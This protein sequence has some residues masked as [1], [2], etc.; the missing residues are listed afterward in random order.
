MIRGLIFDFDGLIIDSETTDFQSWQEIFEA[1]GCSLPLDGWM[2]NVGRASNTFDVYGA[3]EAQAGRNLDRA[4]IRAQHR[5]RN[6]NMLA[7]M[8]T[9]PGVEATIADARRAG[10][11]L[12]VASSSSREWV[13]GHLARLGY[14]ELFDVVKC[15]EDVANAKPAPD[16]F[17]AALAAL[18]LKA[19]EAIVFEDSLNGS[20]AAHRA[21]IF[22]VAVP[23]PLMREQ[24]YQHADLRLA[25]LSD[26]PLSALLEHVNQRQRML[27]ANL[28]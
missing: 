27:D 26:M 17:L 2:A 13:T 22:C 20:L 11:K 4:A 14:L 15:R 9:L 10:L 23:N 16:L 1:H 21:A 7:A 18:G 19:D 28:E 5:Q 24:E 25:Q 8:P 12:A 6:L 3:L